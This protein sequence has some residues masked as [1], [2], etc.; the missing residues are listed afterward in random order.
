MKRIVYIFVLTLL[1]FLSGCHHKNNIT[2]N[3]KEITFFDDLGREVSIHDPKRAAV[4]LG[5]FAHMWTLAGGEVIASADDA[6]EEFD[7]PLSKDAVNLGHTKSLSLEKLFGAQ[8]DFVVASANTKINI[9]WKETLEKAHIPVAYF[10]IND[11]DDYLRVLKICCEITGR[12]DLYEKNG[13]L[14]K[15]KVDSVIEP[16]KLKNFAV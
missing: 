2:D 13:V 3:Q 15:Q 10:S 6:W 5:S 4:L 1:M 8:P 12:D 7:L 11:F 16:T 9:E 14:V